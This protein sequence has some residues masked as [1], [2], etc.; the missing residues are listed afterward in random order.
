MVQTMTV[1][2]AD[3]ERG[4]VLTAPVDKGFYRATITGHVGGGSG[5]VEGRITAGGPGVDYAGFINRGTRKMR[6]R[7]H[8]RRA[9]E[10]AVINR[11]DAMR[12]LV[13][14]IAEQLGR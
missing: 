11:P 4:S 8:I 12:S 2:V 9:V 14:R 13:R 6:Q 7:P 5:F 1:L 10:T 3:A